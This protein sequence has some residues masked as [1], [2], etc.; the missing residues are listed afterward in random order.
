[1]KPSANL[2]HPAFASSLSLLLEEAF[3]FSSS[4]VFFAEL[5]LED[6][7]LLPFVFFP[8][9]ASPVAEPFGVLL[10]VAS[11]CSFSCGSA[12]ADAPF[13]PIVPAPSL[14][15]RLPDEELLLSLVSLSVPF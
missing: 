7:P 1:M 14:P 4:S 3:F 10:S 8:F 11:G 13:D 12:G 9:G 6:E 5:L 15:L 2:V